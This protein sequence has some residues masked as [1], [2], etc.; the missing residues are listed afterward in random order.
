MMS[1]KI[2]PIILGAVLTLIL[3]NAC[4]RQAVPRADMPLLTDTSLSK[5][6][7]LSVSCNNCHAKTGLGIPNYSNHSAKRIKKYLTFYKTDTNGTSVMHRMARG[8]SDEEIALIAGYLEA[9]K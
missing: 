3:L 1:S 5:G 8:L 6:A 4:Q 2:G 9:S 7:L